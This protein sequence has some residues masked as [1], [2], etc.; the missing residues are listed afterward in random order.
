LKSEHKTNSNTGGLV[1]MMTM[2]DNTQVSE[3]EEI[4]KMRE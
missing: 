1:K 2:R 4:A 3:M